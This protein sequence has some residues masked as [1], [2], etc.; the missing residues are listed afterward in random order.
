MRG[1]KNISFFFFIFHFAKFVR[2]EGRKKKKPINHPNK[3]RGEKVIATCK[4]ADN[5]KSIG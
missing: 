2:L 1:T 5:P 3:K 4:K